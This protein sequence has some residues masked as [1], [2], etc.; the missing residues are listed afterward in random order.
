MKRTP[1]LCLT[2][3][4]LVFSFR[5]FKR[6]NESSNKVVVHGELLS[7]ERQIETGHPEWNSSKRSLDHEKIVTTVKADLP[8]TIK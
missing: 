5:I 1:L 4:F 6:E 2:L 8:P 7:A 3:L